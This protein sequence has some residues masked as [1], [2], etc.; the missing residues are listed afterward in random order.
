MLNKIRDY[1]EILVYGSEVNKYLAGEEL[2]PDRAELVIRYLDG[3]KA[4]H[5]L[6]NSCISFDSSQKEEYREMLAQRGYSII[7]FWKSPFRY[8]SNVWFKCY[9]G[10][11]FLA[12]KAHDHG[13]FRTLEEA[14][15]FIFKVEKNDLDLC[16]EDGGE[17]SY[18][19]ISPSGE[20]CSPPDFTVYGYRTVEGSSEYW[21]IKPI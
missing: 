7:I 9:P 2:P 13:P 20:E 19:R 4:Y 21:W 1:E 18:W 11:I 17:I 12:S 8:G 14:E 16:Y 10:D 3:E 6:I 5:E 15:D